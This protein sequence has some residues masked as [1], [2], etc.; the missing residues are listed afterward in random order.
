MTQKKN[1]AEIGVIIGRFQINR[2]H[3]AHKALIDSVL[4]K[5]NKVII[6]L[7]VTTSI[8]SRRNPLDFAS[9]KAMI[10]EEYGNKISAIIPLKDMKNDILWSRQVD[11]KIREVFSIGGVILYGS[12]DSFIPHYHGKFE[13]QE[14]EAEHKISAT[15]IREEVSTVVEK[16]EHFRA[17]MIYAAYQ[18][19][20]HVYPTVDVAI[21]KEDSNEV[22][23][24]R[25]PYEEKFRFIG[26]FTDVEDENYE[27]AASRETRE[28][29]GL[30]VG[31][32]EYLGS[33]RVDDWRYRSNKDR[34]IITLFFKAPY[35][36]GNPKPNDDIAETKWFKIGDLN[37]DNLVTEHV[38]L[39]KL[40][41]PES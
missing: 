23:L 15:E 8:G 10:E 21:V 26:G 3:D 31:A 33:A 30:E 34:G 41:K 17:G 11:E 27:H 32:P 12:R 40:L 29:T 39:L 16:T 13:T 37:K 22:L 18:T 1:K 28:E 20:P 7:G 35:M 5:H 2:L 4:E 38:K 24:G 6:F 9:R 36:Y 19:H 14:L 25:K